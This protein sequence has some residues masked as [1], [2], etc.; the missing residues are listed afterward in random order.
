M[1]I[2]AVKDR[3]RAVPCG[4]GRTC[5]TLEQLKPE[6]LGANHAAA[7]PRSLLRD[8]PAHPARGAETA[9]GQQAERALRDEHQGS[10]AVR[11]QVRGEHEKVWPASDDDSWHRA[12]VHS[13]GLR[14][15]ALRPEV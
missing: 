14:G 9:R 6:R 8:H 11:P 7:P 15:T 4:Q 1:S 2:F 3:Q 5:V 13:D 12:A 10:H